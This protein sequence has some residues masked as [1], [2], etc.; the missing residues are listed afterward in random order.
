[1]WKGIY[2]W[3]NFYIFYIWGKVGLVY[4]SKEGATKYEVAQLEND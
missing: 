3:G 4:P 1:M 2:I